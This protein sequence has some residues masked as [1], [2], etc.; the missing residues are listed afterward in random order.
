[1]KSRMSTAD[2]WIQLHLVSLPRIMIGRQ[3]KSARSPFLLSLTSPW[4]CF[5]N[6]ILLPGTQCIRLGVYFNFI[7]RS[8]QLDEGMRDK[9]SAMFLDHQ[10]YFI[11]PKSG[12]SLSLEVSVHL[13][14]AIAGSDLLL[15]L[16]LEHGPVQSRNTSRRGHY[17]RKDGRA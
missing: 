1:M 3:Q 16:D 6:K 17:S 4:S 7:T 9:P 14:L 2:I 8:I 13:I 12:C 10:K 11:Y 15:R 5:D